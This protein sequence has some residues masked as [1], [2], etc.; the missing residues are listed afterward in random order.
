MAEYLIQEETLNGLADKI[1]ILSGTEETMSPAEM[2]DELNTFNNDMNVVISEQDNLIAQ[3]AAA[4]EGKTGVSGGS[5]GGLDTSDA[6]ATATDIAKGKT[7][8]VNGQKVTGTA[9]MPYQTTIPTVDA[10]TKSISARGSATLTTFATQSTHFFGR[11]PN[12]NVAIYVNIDVGTNA[13]LVEGTAYLYNLG[14]S[15]VTLD[16]SS[17]SLAVEIV[18]L[19]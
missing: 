15:S 8:Y 9:V 16:Y 6:T 17:N 19:Y 5:S 12:T 18:E 1:R 11:I 10:G 3:I 4:L 14:G 2:N 7:A 13:G